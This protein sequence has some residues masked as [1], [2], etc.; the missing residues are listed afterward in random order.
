MHNV[1]KMFF[2]AMV[3]FFLFTFLLVRCLISPLEGFAY[4]A[5][6]IAQGD[7]N[8]SL[9]SVKLHD[10][11]KDLYNAFT[12]MKES[13]NSYVEDLKNTTAS[14]ERIE[15]ELN[16]AHDIQMGMIPKIFPPFPD[17]ADVDLHAILKPAKEVGGD[18]Y[19]FYIQNEQL[20]FVIGDV[21]GKGVPAS[22]L[23]AVTRSLF[24]SVSEYLTSPCEIVKSMNDSISEQNEANMFVTLFV[25]VLDLP[26]GL[27][28]FCNAGHNPPVLINK[29][30]EVGYMKIKSNLP[31]GLM[32]GF[33][34][35]N[36]SIQLESQS[37]LFTYTDGVVEAENSNQALYSEEKLLKTLALNNQ[38][39]V[40]RMVNCI[41]ESVSEHVLEAE[42]SD[43]L[44]IL[45]VNY[46]K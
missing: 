17:R 45:I 22:L 26:T 46:K 31:I 2:A 4:S 39:G 1:L 35:E 12:Y 7:F 11:M 21:S 6:Q 43:D 41:V 27:L 24:R 3:A 42:P 33:L 16:I 28:T 34:Y 37:K 44:T 8:A 40:R 15:S 29:S 13:L 23:M 30:G 10:E 20:F 5:R 19:D 25:G 36:E 14:K 38:F 32:E 18:L 9:P